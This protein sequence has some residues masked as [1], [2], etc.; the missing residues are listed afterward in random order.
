M[1]INNDKVKT[2]QLV[3]EILKLVEKLNLG[4]AV[5]HEALN[6]A[7]ELLERKISKKF[8]VKVFAASILYA[9]CKAKG[10]PIIFK[11]IVSILNLNRKEQRRATE[12]YN[13]LIQKVKITSKPSLKDYVERLADS[14]RLN[15][16]IKN[17]AIKFIDEFS[18]EKV[19]AGKSPVSLAAAAVYLAAKKN[20]I[21]ITQKEVASKTYI[22]E[23]TL[24]KHFKELKEVLSEREKRHEIRV[25]KVT[26]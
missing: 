15:D 9:S 7:Q 10:H 6:L 17:Q 2:I 5:F 8:S 14:L 3:K 26:S 23:V 13:T 21:P 22:S 12:I 1:P 16:K 11:E 24:R 19:I 18:Q 4:Y 25:L 20:R